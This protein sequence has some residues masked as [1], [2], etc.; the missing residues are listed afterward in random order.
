MNVIANGF[1]IAVATAIHDQG[2]V[3]PTEY[4]PTELVPVIHANGVSAQQ[5]SHPRHQV[6]FR[7]L[8]YQMKMIAHEA[9]R[10]NL[11]AGFLTRLRQG[12]QEILTIHIVQE[13]VL[14]A[15]SAAHEV[16]DGPLILH[17][18]FTRHN[19]EPANSRVP[20]QIKTN[21]TMG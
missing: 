14:A 9:I 21:Q 17:S 13:N 20:S 1:Q 5:P 3:A 11:K 12:F 10:M 6:G 18:H 19:S 7:R 2:F 15:I 16:V 4:V 8:D